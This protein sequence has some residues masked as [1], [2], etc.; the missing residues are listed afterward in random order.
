MANENMNRQDQHQQQDVEIKERLHHIKNK[1]LVMSGKGGVGK[2][3]VAAYLSV[4]LAKK[5][6][7]VGLMDVDLHGPSIPRMLGLKGNIGPGASEG[8]ARPIKYI[9]NMVDYKSAN[10]SNIESNSILFLGRLHNSKIGILK[11]LLK[12]ASE[13]F[14][15]VPD[16]RIIIAGDGESRDEIEQIANGVNGLF[17]EEKI[18]LIG[19]V[20]NPEYHIS[21]AS[22][23]IGVGRV[24]L[25]AMIQCKPTIIGHSNNET[26]LVGD[27]VDLS[28]FTKLEATNFTGRNYIRTINPETLAEM[29]INILTDTEQAQKIA[30]SCRSYVLEKFETATVVN[31]I[32]GT[33]QGLITEY[34]GEV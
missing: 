2:S 24:A 10:T 22:V 7:K 4:A 29:I 23:V 25:E 14:T 20:D 1:I 16:A 32:E 18:T 34:I 21:R 33:Y 12:S 26:D 11:I 5:G 19:Y 8:K 17:N 3:S 13:I 15:H 30:E 31:E 27:K 6:F 28:N 9:P